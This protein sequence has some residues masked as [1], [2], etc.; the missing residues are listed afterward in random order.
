MEH[1]EVCWPGPRGWSMSK[2]SIIAA[3]VTTRCSY[4]EPSLQPVLASFPG[5]WLQNLGK[6]VILS[7]S[8]EFFLDFLFPRGWHLIIARAD[9]SLTR[10][11]ST[12][13]AYP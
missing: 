5:T 10:W 8:V 12:R 11:L 9:D 13:L 2:L 3:G 6:R 7:V 1:A 4:H